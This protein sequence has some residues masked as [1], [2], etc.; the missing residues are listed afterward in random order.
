MRS[1]SWLSPLAADGARAFCAGGAA[2]AAS[3]IFFNPIEVVVQRA[4]VSYDPRSSARAAAGD[5]AH[6]AAALWRAHGLRGFYQGYWAVR[7][8]AQHDKRDACDAS[9]VAHAC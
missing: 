7:R 8:D 4:V 3:L 5:V 2:N 1:V 6:T 9:A